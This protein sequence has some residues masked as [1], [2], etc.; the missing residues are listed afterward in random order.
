MGLACPRMVLDKYYD[1][2]NMYMCTCLG[3]IHS[4]LCVISLFV[5]FVC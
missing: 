5:C 1:I 3:D 4:V 2:H